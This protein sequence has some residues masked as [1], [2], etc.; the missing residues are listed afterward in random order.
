MDK[1]N[2]P[3]A[4]AAYATSAY[5]LFRTAGSLAGA[6]ILSRFPPAVLRRQRHFAWRRLALVWSFLNNGRPCTFQLLLIG[7][8]NANLFPIM[9]SQGDPASARKEKWNFRSDDHGDFRR[10]GVSA[11]DGAGFDLSGFSN[12]RRYCHA[13]RSCL[14]DFR[15]RL[16]KKYPKKRHNLRRPQNF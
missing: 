11:R 3:L 1:L 2:L 12:R 13:G 8:N 15:Y 10:C 9:F 7:F 5:F 16:D 14:S 4:N 6:F